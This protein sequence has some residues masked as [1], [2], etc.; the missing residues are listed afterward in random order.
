M[1]SRDSN[2]AT[3]IAGHP[4]DYAVTMLFLYGNSRLFF[5]SLQLFS[6]APPAA[7]DGHTDATY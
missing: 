2:N 3:E 5:P 4:G 1:M 6:H 7:H